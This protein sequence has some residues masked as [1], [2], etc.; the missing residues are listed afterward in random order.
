[1]SPQTP[2]NQSHCSLP[3]TSLP[4]FKHKTV[5]HREGD[6]WSPL[7]GIGRAETSLYLMFGL[8]LGSSRQGL[9]PTVT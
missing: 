2:G 5:S 1:M 3:D 6:A 8:S 9:W 4:P 7:S